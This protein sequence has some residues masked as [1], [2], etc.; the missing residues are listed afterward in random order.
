MAAEMITFRNGAPF[1]G[2]EQELANTLANQGGL[3]DGAVEIYNIDEDP[4]KALLPRRAGTVRVRLA[5]N[6]FFTH[7]SVHLHRDFANM[8]KPSDWAP[9]RTTSPPREPRFPSDPSFNKADNE[10]VP[11]PQP[12]T[13]VF[14]KE[15][16]EKVVHVYG[17]PDFEQFKKDMGSLGIVVYSDGTSYAGTM[18]QIADKIVADVFPGMEPRFPSNSS[19]TEPDIA[20][21]PAEQSPPRPVKQKRPEPIKKQESSPLKTVRFNEPEQR[22][23]ILQTPDFV[24]KPDV[25]HPL[26]HKAVFVESPKLVAGDPAEMHMVLEF[27]KDFTDVKDVTEEAVKEQSTWENPVLVAGEDDSEDDNEFTF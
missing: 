4:T 10:P 2:T 14:M 7:Y 19:F 20:A 11:L 22:K 23:G 6:S 21:V 18:Q 9:E 5:G 24:V 26:V 15:V 3:M 8:S 25:L 1:T 16:A 13:A 12:D 27:N 17:H